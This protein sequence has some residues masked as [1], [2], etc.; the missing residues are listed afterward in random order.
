MAGGS[1]AACERTSCAG[2]TT[3]ISSGA[4][5][6]ATSSGRSSPS[7]CGC[8][9]TRSRERTAMKIERVEVRE[10]C[11]PLRFPFETSFARTT[12][13]EFLLLSVSADGLT[14]YGE[15]MADSDPYYLPETNGTVAHVLEQFLVPLVL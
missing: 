9:S 10:L 1:P 15:C 7:S 8:A 13:K 4:R 12:R 3:I 6:G 5:I 2:S 14:G 11:L